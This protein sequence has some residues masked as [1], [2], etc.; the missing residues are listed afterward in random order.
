MAVGLVLMLLAKATALY[1]P[2]NQAQVR[3]IHTA[4]RRQIRPGGDQEKALSLLTTAS[5]HGH[6]CRSYMLL[7]LHHQRVGRMAQRA[8]H[9]ASADD[10]SREQARTAFRSG[11]ALRSGETEAEIELLQAWALLESNSGNMHRACFL[12]RRAAQLER[13]GH[14]QLA[15]NSPARAAFQWAQFREYI[16]SHNP[17][18]RPPLSRG[19]TSSCE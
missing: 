5:V 15:C 13:V 4:A 14:I 16:R 3:A 9:D 18:A 8:A 2:L 1:V 11:L 19:K 10:L 12:L 7:S 17:L 6:S